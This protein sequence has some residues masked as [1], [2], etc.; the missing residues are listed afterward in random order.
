M[1]DWVGVTVVEQAHLAPCTVDKQ[2]ETEVFCHIVNAEVEVHA[3]EGY[4]SLALEQQFAACLPIDYL[5]CRSNLYNIA[6]NL[7]RQQCKLC[8]G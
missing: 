3:L 2:F 8:N 6:V 5:E 4:G 1:D 7:H